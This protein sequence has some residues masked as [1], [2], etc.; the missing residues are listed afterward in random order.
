M[1]R[2]GETQ[3]FSSWSAIVWS[4]VLGNFGHFDPLERVIYKTLLI[5]SEPYD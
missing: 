4:G 5:K 3:N 1:A 2:N